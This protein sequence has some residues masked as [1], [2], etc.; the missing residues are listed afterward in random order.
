MHVIKK[1]RNGL[2]GMTMLSGLVALAGMPV[3]HAA[4]P[5]GKLPA[6]L[7]VEGQALELNGVG[8]RNRFFMDVYNAGLYLPAQSHNP[9]AIIERD[10][11]QAVRLEITSS[12]VTRERFIDSIEDGVR[13]SAGDDYDRYSHLIDELRQEMEEQDITVAVGDV[14]GFDYVP[15]EGTRILRN[16]EVMRTIEGLDFKRVLFGIYL[17]KEPIQDSL[18]QEMLGEDT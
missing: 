3:A 6:S 12:R 10:E 14:F 2:I 1:L 17:G 4:D 7:T 16:D 18:K 5:E 13:L 9:E 11:V 15:G 8:K